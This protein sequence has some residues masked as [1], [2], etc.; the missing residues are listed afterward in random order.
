MNGTACNSSM[1]A[2][3]TIS[4]GGCAPEET[5]HRRGFECRRRHQPD[6]GGN[7][8]R[9]EVVRQ[10]QEEA[11][12]DKHHRVP[13]RGHLERSFRAMNSTSRATPASRPKMVRYSNQM[14]TVPATTSRLSSQR[15]G[16]RRRA[17][18][19]PVRSASAR[20]AMAISQCG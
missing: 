16:S 15:E 1:P 7:A 6:P 8:L 2:R 12:H 20:S 9:V 17:I 14:A 5:D 10:Q 4:A 19:S 13:A 11:E 3:R 18:Q